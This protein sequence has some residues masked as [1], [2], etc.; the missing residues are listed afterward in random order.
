MKEPVKQV[1]RVASQTGDQI[2]DI[3]YEG[4]NTYER[5]LTKAPIKALH[6]SLF[7]EVI[8][9]WSTTAPVSN[10]RGV[11]ENLIE[12][13]EIEDGKGQIV[14]LNSHDIRRLAKT[15][16]GSDSPALYAKNAS[17]LSSPSTGFAEYGSLTSGQKV[18]FHESIEI[19]FENI[20]AQANFTDTF[21]QYNGR[22]QNIIRIKMKA[23]TNLSQPSTS[24][25][26]TWTS[27]ITA[28]VRPI[29]SGTAGAGKRWH[30]FTKEANFLA[31]TDRSVIK[32]DEVD[33]LAALEMYVTK[34]A[35]NDPITVEEMKQVEFTLKVKKDGAVTTLKPQSS[36]LDIAYEALNKKQVSSLQDGYAFMSMIQANLLESALANNYEDLDLEVK[37]GSGLGGYSAPGYKLRVVVHNIN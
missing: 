24:S 16:I 25:D 21:L 9:T 35:D 8:P 14:S 34:G 1:Q 19:P 12:E 3:N 18:Q 36:L 37:M 20:M 5:P 27:T 4:A 32:L 17:D 30:R 26:A 28:R 23:L 29:V 11:M 10:G 33:N 13:I 6:L 22:K 7:G 2:Q 15:L 31:A